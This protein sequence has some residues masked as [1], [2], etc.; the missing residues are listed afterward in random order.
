MRNCL[1]TK[2][3]GVVD[4]DSLMKFGEFRIDINAR[5][6]YVFSVKA[7]NN[8]MTVESGTRNSVLVDGN[9]VSLPWLFTKGSGDTGT[10]NLS[11]QENYSYNDF[12]FI[13]RSDLKEIIVTDSNVSSVVIK[14]FKGL[15]DT[16]ETITI[17]HAS[18]DGYEE[19]HTEWF[20]DFTHLTKL[21]MID[22]KW[23][24][25]I[26]DLPLNCS[27]FN[28]GN[29]GYVNANLYGNI[30]TTFGERTNVIHLSFKG[31]NCT[32]DIADLADAQVA[33][34]R[35]SGQIRILCSRSLVTNSATGA[36][37]K[38]GYLHFTTDTTTYPRGWYWTE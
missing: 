27:I 22:T 25:D 19:L 30:V 11:V 16:I 3:I 26:A 32:G 18:A 13:E 21:A 14:S 6:G 23:C 10:V 12:S 24:G 1:V 36:T 5:A 38:D 20:K 9:P 4:N 2:Y 35:T 29:D 8:V 31:S 7:T 28:I 34:G 33:S 37:L 17:I 15:E